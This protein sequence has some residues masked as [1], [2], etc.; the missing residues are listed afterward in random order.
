MKMIHDDRNLPTKEET[1]GASESQKSKKPKFPFPG[2]NH[3]EKETCLFA[4]HHETAMRIK[5]KNEN[6]TLN[7]AGVLSN[8]HAM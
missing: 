5:A 6:R 3:R 4:I 2:G 1:K 8:T 7:T